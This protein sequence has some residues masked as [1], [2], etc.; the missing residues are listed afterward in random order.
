MSD[1]N[2]TCRVLKQA[3]AFHWQRKRH[4]FVINVLAQALYTLFGAEDFYLETLR[5]GCFECLAMGGACVEGP[6]G[7]LGGIIQAPLVLVYHFLAVGLLSVWIL[8]SS[9]SLWRLLLTLIECEGV[10]IKACWVLFL[11]RSVV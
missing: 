7:L 1:L 3:K 9:H 2:N 8:L 6:A 10:L 5:R 11:L 4:S